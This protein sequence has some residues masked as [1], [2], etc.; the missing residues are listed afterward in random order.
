MAL[1]KKQRQIVWNKSG[2][3]CWYCG[4]QLPERGWHAD[5]F[6]PVIRELTRVKNP[7]GSMYSHRT[8]CSGAMHKAANDTI[9]NMVPSCAPCNNFKFTFPVEDFRQELEAQIDRARRSSVNFRNAERFGLIEIKP[10]KVI[11]W[12]EKMGLSASQGDKQCSQ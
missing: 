9:E 4:N 7:A 6:E 10:A 3:Y 8:V 1:T 5:H 11:F 2:G 12:F